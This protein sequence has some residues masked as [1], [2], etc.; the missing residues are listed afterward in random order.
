MD[1]FFEL[2]NFS[3]QTVICL[4]NF[5]GVHRGHQKL[6]TETVTHAK[7]L[8]LQ[9]VALT[10]EPHPELVLCPKKPLKRILTNEL[11][12]EF[13][14]KLGINTLI[15]LPFNKQIAEM[16]PEDFIAKVLVERCKT[17]EIFTGFNYSFGKHATGNINTLKKLS[18]KWGYAFHAIPPYTVNKHIVSSSLIRNYLAKG[19]VEEAKELL[20]YWPTLR[21]K[22]VYGDQRGSRALGFPTANLKIE[23]N[24][25][26]PANGVY[27]STVHYENKSFFGMTNI[28]SKPTVG[29]NLPKTIE[30]NIF[31]FN[32]NL[33][34]KTLTIQLRKYL[35]Q[36]KKFSSLEKLRQQLHK[37]QIEAINY[38]HQTCY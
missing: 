32:N 8:N 9:S 2:P 13:I 4:G 6:I 20:G 12:T 5:D 35:R 37:D 28:G 25:L 15:F 30:V 36:E 17:A 34:G 24:L 10:F 1:I 3:N 19:K 11:K 7:L 23:R 14:A 29:K 26:I 31:D 27:V 33:Y 21:G 22:V 38:L 16:T 18:K